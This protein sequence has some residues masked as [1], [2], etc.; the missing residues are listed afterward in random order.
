[1]KF[2]RNGPE[3]TS[4]SSASSWGFVPLVMI[5][6]GVAVGASIFDFIGLPMTVGGVSGGIG[7][8]FVSGAVLRHLYKR[9][10]RK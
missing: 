3:S 7:A 2:V 8:Y 5:F 1:M 6:G 10:A 9:R 4:R